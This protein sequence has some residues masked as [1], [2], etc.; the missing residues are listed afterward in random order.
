MI[1]IQAANNLALVTVANISAGKSIIHI[2]DAVL[3][4]SILSYPTIAAAAKAYHLTLL[5]ALL[6]KTSLRSALT[7]ANTAVTVF[8]PTSEVSDR[9]ITF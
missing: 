8:A 3:V 9:W 6:S 7:D 2:I 4:P 5:M 1:K